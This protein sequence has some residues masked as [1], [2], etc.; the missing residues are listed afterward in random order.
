MA[1]EL[2]QF[3]KQTENFIFEVLQELPNAVTAAAGQAASEIDRRISETGMNASGSTLGHYTDGV[4]KKKRQKIGHTTAFVNLQFTGDMWREIGVTDTKT[5]GTITTATIAGK[6]DETNDKLFFN[7]IRYNDDILV[8]SQLEEDNAAELI[9]DAMQEI[10][11]K[12]F[13]S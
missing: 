2:E 6:F 7:S 10:I 13:G 9:D 11:D 12:N 4:Y 8:L 1:L 3:I 5:Q